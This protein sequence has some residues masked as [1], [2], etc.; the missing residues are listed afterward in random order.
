V[1]NGNFMAKNARNMI[2]KDF[3]VKPAY[4]EDDI[5]MQQLLLWLL[6]QANFS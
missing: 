6:S 5:N 3:T 1:T 4:I 2:N